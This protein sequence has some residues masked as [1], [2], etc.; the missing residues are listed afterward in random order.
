MLPLVDH[1]RTS[2]QTQ[3]PY[4]LIS[5]KTQTTPN[6]PPDV[7][8]PPERLRAH[9]SGNSI[10]AK[11]KRVTEIDDDDDDDEIGRRDYM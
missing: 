4:L 10:I 1:E 9:G 7:A 3:Q 5:S 8:A 2:V 11:R 6:A